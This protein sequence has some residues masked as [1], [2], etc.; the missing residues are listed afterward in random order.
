M[1]QMR[2]NITHRPRTDRD[3]ASVRNP[4][5]KPDQPRNNLPKR[6]TSLSQLYVVTHLRSSRSGLLNISMHL[7]PSG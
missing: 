5:Y 2:R 6:R 4:P 3:D 7:I 1:R